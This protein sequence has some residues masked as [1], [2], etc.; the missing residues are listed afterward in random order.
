MA[1][2]SDREYDVK[3]IVAH[4]YSHV[5]SGPWGMPYGPGGPGMVQKRMSG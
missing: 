1:W 5:V 3:D 4:E 2:P